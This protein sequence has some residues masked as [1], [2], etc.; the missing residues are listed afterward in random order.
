MLCGINRTLYR[1]TGFDSGV[2][3][4]A[5]LVRLSDLSVVESEIIFA[6]IPDDQLYYADVNFPTNGKYY[7]IV[8][9]NGQRTTTAIFEVGG[10]PGIVTVSRTG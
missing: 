3:V 9:E 1:A 6:E 10:Y 8:Y 4:T 2:T 5:K 7:M